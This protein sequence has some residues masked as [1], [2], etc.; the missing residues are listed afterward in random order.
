MAFSDL[1]T[2][3]FA[4]P[5]P[6]DFDVY[7]LEYSPELHDTVINIAR[8]CSGTVEGIGYPYTDGIERYYVVA[9]DL[10]WADWLTLAEIF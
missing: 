1:V 9:T 2:Q 5:H 8:D 4:P 6:A 7:P 10:S 3:F